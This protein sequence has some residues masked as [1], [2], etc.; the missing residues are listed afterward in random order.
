M[1]RRLSLF[2]RGADEHD[3]AIQLFTVS[4]ADGVK[5]IRTL[6]SVIIKIHE[7]ITHSAFQL[8]SQP[9]ERVNRWRDSA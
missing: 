3:E 2:G 4:I 5:Q 1:T 8:N 7:E 6:V 9:V